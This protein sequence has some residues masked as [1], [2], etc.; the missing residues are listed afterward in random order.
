M[1]SKSRPLCKIFEKVG[2]VR[3][4]KIL[5]TFKLRTFSDEKLHVT[6]NINDDIH[7]VG[8]IMGKGENAGNLFP[9]CYLKAFSSGSSGSCVA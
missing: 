1:G 9:K 3:D 4:G 7:R 6:Q 8:N 2:Y 5:V